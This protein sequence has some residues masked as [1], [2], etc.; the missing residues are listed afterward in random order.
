MIVISFVL[1]IVAAATLVIGLFQDTL[2]FI[3]I[4]I[5]SCVVAMVFLGIGVLQRRTGRVRALPQE[6]GRPGM[7]AAPPRITEPEPSR[8]D[9]SWRATARSDLDETPWRSVTGAHRPVAGRGEP[10]QE[11]A[12]P[13]APRPAPTAPRAPRPAPTPPAAP[14]VERVPAAEVTREEV[15]EEAPVAPTAPVTSEP[16]PEPVAA[17]APAVAVAKRATRK[18]PAAKRSTKKA[19]RKT[20]K[21]AVK[22]AAKKTAKRVTAKKATEKRTTGVAARRELNKVRGLG[23]AKQRALL[24]AFGSLEAIRA[25]SVQELTQVRGVGEA[26]AR[27][28]L[29]QPR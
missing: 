19:A 27:E 11:P 16:S 7:P 1:V 3:W 4:S 5:V 22:K 8:V 24:D 21:R 23:P 18:A 26:T 14:R 29:R 10:Q 25:A 15:T 2:T 6:T 17:E 20:A 12:A 9:V 13:R 28:I